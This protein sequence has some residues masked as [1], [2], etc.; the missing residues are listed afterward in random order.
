LSGRY[1]AESV[2]GPK[3]FLGR[4][5]PSGLS[6][7]RPLGSASCPV[8][9]SPPTLLKL[10]LLA[11]RGTMGLSGLL[12]AG[13]P[14]QAHQTK[15]PNPISNT[16]VVAVLPGARRAPA[17]ARARRRRCGRP[18]GSKSSRGKVSPSL[19]ML[20]WAPGFGEPQEAAQGHPHPRGARHGA[21]VRSQARGIQYRCWRAP[22]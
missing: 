10:V 21:G 16:P 19:R 1:W 17:P 14:L 8:D 3:V 2:S 13:A 22:D 12:R 5:W 15:P 9:R 20:T 7:A 11:H 6:P 4:E 18:R